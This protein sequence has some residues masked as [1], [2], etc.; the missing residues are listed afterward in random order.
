MSKE[1]AAI[2]DLLLTDAILRYA[3]ELRIGTPSAVDRDT[4]LPVQEFDAVSSLN[5][6]LEA[7]TLAEF[8]ADLAPP[9][10]EYKRLF[11][12]LGHYR[13]LADDGTEA[14]E[15]VDQ[16]VANMERWRWLPHRLEP[17]RVM[18]NA[19]DATLEVI[20]NDQ[21]ILR[22]KVIVGTADHPTPIFRAVATG[23]TVNPPW[24]VPASIASNEFLPRLRSNPNFL[25]SQNIVLLNGPVDDPHGT[26]IDWNRV[27]PESVSLQAAATAGSRQ[28]PRPIEA[29]DAQCVQRLSA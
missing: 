29:R 24:N 18:V 28:R 23:V 10:P 6:A 1:D 19:A 7:G 5:T 2:H 14:S 9:H 15:R 8:L 21:V 17:R 22:S 3:R 16:I 27:S 20:D 12:A 4:D 13:K 26:R 11:A 25:L